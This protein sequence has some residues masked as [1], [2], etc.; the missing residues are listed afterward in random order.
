MGDEIVNKFD[1]EALF[2]EKN[3]KTRKEVNKEFKL[4]SNVA[5]L[6]SECI[7]KGGTDHMKVRVCASSEHINQG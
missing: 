5:T 7:F 2:I 3:R 4:T 6:P 1:L